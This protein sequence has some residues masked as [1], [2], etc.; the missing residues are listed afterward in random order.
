MLRQLAS[1]PILLLAISPLL[2]LALAC[3]GGAE[4]TPTPAALSP[5][6][7]EA[8][9]TSA[10]LNGGDLPAG[11]AVADQLVMQPNPYGFQ[12]EIVNLLRQLNYEAALFTRL[13][14]A[15]GSEQTSFVEESLFLYPSESAAGEGYR[16][17]VAEGAVPFFFGGWPRV[18]LDLDPGAVSPGPYTANVGQQSV[19]FTS[20]CPTRGQPQQQ[21]DCTGV[22]AQEGHLLVVLVVSEPPPVDPVS[23]IQAVSAR[24]AQELT[25][26]RADI[27][28]PA[29][30]SARMLLRA[31]DVAKYEF[32]DGVRV[33]EHGFLYDKLTNGRASAPTGALGGS[34]VTF[35]DPHTL[36]RIVN[37]V[38]VYDSEASAKAGF[39]FEDAEAR[40]SGVTSTPLEGGDEGQAYYGASGQIGTSSFTTSM[41]FA[42]VR[43]GT[44]VATVRIETPEE[45]EM[46]IPTSAIVESLLGRIRAEIAH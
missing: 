41:D 19:S 6:E 3:G 46:P 45:G 1:R 11:W 13:T 2:P 7:E 40:P 36:S 16:A 28:S 32:S 5:P 23:L 25:L 20:S 24:V 30:R 42:I 27:S 15:P 12:P 44:V 14:Q 43:L 31:E 17:A 4:R 22:L 29:R 38:T 34:S 39:A 18:Y 26:A 9:L 10:S 37:S 33:H 35:S 21:Q 8:V